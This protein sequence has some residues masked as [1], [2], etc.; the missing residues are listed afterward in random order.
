MP[1]SGLL[2]PGLGDHNSTGPFLS[3]G[4]VIPTEGQA[5]VRPPPSHSHL[6][7]I[8]KG[9]RSSRH[10]LLPRRHMRAG[11]VW[12]I[13]TGKQ[14]SASG[15]AGLPPFTCHWRGTGLLLVKSQSQLEEDTD[16]PQPRG[17][18][19]ASE[20]DNLLGGKRGFSPPFPGVDTILKSSRTNVQD[21]V[22]GTD[23]PL[24]RNR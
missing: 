4:A 13:G 23:P 9:P 17:Q 12:E 6:P 16:T 10:L 14:V 5:V 11:G 7:V 21:R 24:P 1:H 3:A 22:I 18:A 20:C 19:S 15:G 2:S 8:L